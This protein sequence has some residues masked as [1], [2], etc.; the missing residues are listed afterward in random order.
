MFIYISYLRPI[1]THAC[2]MRSYTAKSHVKLLLKSPNSTIRQIL[3]M[4]LCVRNFHIHKEIEL[5]RLN[6]FIQHLNLNFHLVFENTDDIA[7]NTLAE[8]DHNDPRNR[9]RVKTGLRLNTLLQ[10]FSRVLTFF[11][12]FLTSF[13]SCKRTRGSLPSPFFLSTNLTRILSNCPSLVFIFLR[14]FLNEK[15]KLKFFYKKYKTE[16]M[17]KNN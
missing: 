15:K 10:T 16:K 2:M 6:D 14:L 7:L 13:F 9:R 3:D 12:C 11:N 1:L 5:P 17:K 4:P 8:Y